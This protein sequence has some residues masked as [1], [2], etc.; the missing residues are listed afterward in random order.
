MTWNTVRHPT[1][2]HHTHSHPAP[3]S[4]T[5]AL[6]TS[7]TDY[8]RA[9]A[10][11]GNQAKHQLGKNS[12]NTITG[13]W[14]LLGGKKFSREVPQ[15]TL[16][17]SAPVI[18]HPTLPG[19]PAYKVN[20]LLPAPSPL[21]MT[22][23]NTPAAS[24]AECFITVSE[25][26]T[27]FLGSLLE[28][29]KDFLGHQVVDTVINVLSFS[30]DIQHKALTKAA[31]DAGICI[32]Q[33]PDDTGAVAVYALAGGDDVSVDHTQLVVDLG[34]SLLELASLSMKVW[35]TLWLLFYTKVK[36]LITSADIDLFDVDEIIYIKGSACLP[37]LDEM[38]LEGF[39]ESAIT[40]F[41]AGTVVGVG[42][43]DPTTILA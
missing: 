4:I 2:Q 41:K 36:E 27:I 7:T 32:L 43:G 14:N 30:D 20:V 31:E 16:L 12:Q 39:T 23:S 18:Q 9:N 3:L 17:V 8:T 25:A 1:I 26:T 19:T 6:P 42:V 13:F 33:L 40:P 22:T 28:F 5:Q 10:T 37:G 29:A 35:H 24:Q 21:L 34:T 38:L 11:I 15:A